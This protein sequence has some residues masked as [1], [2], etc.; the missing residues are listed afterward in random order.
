MRQCQFIIGFGLRE[1]EGVFFND[2]D[3][4]MGIFEVDKKFL[5]EGMERVRKDYEEKRVKQ[6]FLEIMMMILVWDFQGFEELLLQ[7]VKF[8]EVVC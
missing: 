4:L 3:I 1:R 7:C 6:K 5:K 8:I 2:F